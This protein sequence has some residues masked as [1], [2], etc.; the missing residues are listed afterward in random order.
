VAV[1]GVSELVFSSDRPLTYLVFPALIW[2][3]IRFGQRGATVAVAVTVGVS[4]WHT[5]HFAGPF[6]YFSITHGVVSAQL[7]ILAATATTL[8]LAAVVSERETFSTGLSAS[9]ARLVHAAQEERRRL[10]HNLHDGAQQS[11]TALGARLRTAREELRDGGGIEQSD[12][13]LVAAEEQLGF[14]VE[15]LREL[16]HGIHPAVLT[17]HGLPEAI[18]HIAARST[19]PVRV[20]ALP[21]VRLDPRVEVAAYYVVAEAVTNAQKHAGAS[22]IRVTATLSGGILRVEVAD[23]GSGGAAESRGTG[24][25]GLRDRV[26]AVGGTFAVSSVPGHGTR[27]GAWLFDSHPDRR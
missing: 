25:Q 12:K 23:D 18:E 13:A 14:A 24:L 26:E 2:A 9:R 16:A 19:V 20:V 27:V 4:A 5:A 11:L 10:E 7:F 15:E 21:T 8:A 6:V 17:R 3:A 22:V 1:A